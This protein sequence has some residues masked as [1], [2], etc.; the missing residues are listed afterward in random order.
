MSESSTPYAPPRAALEDA[1]RPTSR[2]DLAGPGRRLVAHIV[3]SIAW[4]VPSL[5]GL[6]VTADIDRYLEV[7]E[8][9]EWD[10]LSTPELGLVLGGYVVLAVLHAVSIV[11]GGCSL[12]KRLL[13][14]HV[15]RLD[16]RSCGLLRYVF[17]RWFVILAIA[18]GFEVL[19]GV[20]GVAGLLLLVDNLL[21][22]GPTQRT[23]H[24]RIAS[25]RVVRTRP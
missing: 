1:P 12:G 16:G 15:V 11:K 9:G 4:A 17:V 25:T 7:L 3:D 13:G 5:L 22:L 14:I 18:I 6:F 10:L 21:I 2:A 8:S 19:V 24:D 23:L 20:V